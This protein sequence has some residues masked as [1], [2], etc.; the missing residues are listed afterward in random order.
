M[1]GAP[2]TTAEQSF[3]T[4]LIIGG[5]GGTEDN[6][7]LNAH[8]TQNSGSGKAFGILKPVYSSILFSFRLLHENNIRCPILKELFP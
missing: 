7:V 4:Y 1:E 5:L 6:I 8:M 3:R 2:P